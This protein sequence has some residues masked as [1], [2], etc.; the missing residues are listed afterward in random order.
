[1]ELTKRARPEV[2]RYD[3]V[4]IG[5][6]VIMGSWNKQVKRFVQENLNDLNEGRTAL[7]VCCGDL[8][9]P[10]RRGDAHE[11]YITTPMEEM[12]LVPDHVAL[13]GGVIDFSKY[14][15]MVKTLMKN[16]IRSGQ[17]KDFDIDEVYDLRDWDEIGRF[18][19]DLAH[20]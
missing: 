12:G 19:S 1:M 9:D 6:N 17:G 20:S 14:G 2:R 13:M 16:V 10:S 15:M 3:L 18:A 4:V 11:N 7:F 8:L 5:T